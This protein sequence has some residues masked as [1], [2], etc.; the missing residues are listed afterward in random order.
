MAVEFGARLHERTPIEAIACDGGEVTV[1]AGGRTV[2]AAKL[3]VAAGPWSAPALQQLGYRVPLEVTKEQAM[4]FTLERPDA[5]AIG[6]FPIWI[7]MDDPSFYGFPVFGEANAVKITQDAGGKSVDPD[8]RS[9]DEDS[10][11]SQR[12]CSFVREH[13]PAVG[14]VKIVKTCL[15][16]LTPDR[17]F[18]IDRLPQHSQVSV[19]VGA[20]HAFKFA[21]AIG[22][23]LALDAL[24]EAL[25][26]E[27]SDFS[28]VRPIL[29]MPDPP[30]SYMV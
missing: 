7:W 21:S 4:Y 17:D 13:L 1:R 30:K 23:V 2:R 24:G 16:T 20:G 14:P 18:I 12:V 8:R 9:F 27:L 22:R 15:Y 5:F 3:I 26:P 28:I 11:L 6:R 10:E 25:P 19:A 29:Q